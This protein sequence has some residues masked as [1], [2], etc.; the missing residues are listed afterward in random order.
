MLTK[1]AAVLSIGLLALAYQA[2]LP[3]PTKICGTPEG[4]PITAPRVELR[5]GRHLAYKEHG[6][7]K[8]QAKYKVIFVHGFH[9][10]RHHVVIKQ[11]L[12]K[13]VAEELGV[14]IVS[15]DRPGYGESDP[16]PKRTMKSIALDI[17]ELAD[18]LK[19]GEKF[20]VVGFSMGGQLVWA[21]LKYIP[22]RL[23]GA[24][25]LAPV[26]N[27]WWKGF[28][29]NLS[30]EAYY[31]Q[32]PQDQWAVRVAHYFPWLINW[33]NTQKWFPGSSAIAG[34]I[35]IF[36]PQDL[37]ILSRFPRS[38]AHQKQIKQQGQHESLHRDM[39]CGFGSWEFSP[40]ELQNPFPNGE[41]AV[42]LWQG[43]DDR[44]V[45][46]SLQRYIV[47]KLPWI[48]YHELQG[49]GHIFPFVESVAILKAQLL[50]ENK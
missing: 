37:Q 46:V 26:V 9:S 44:L 14:Y 45:P 8:E 33:W 35:K 36:S 3:E 38:E 12:A 16:D 11:N 7:P 34:N 10:C 18:K 24:T 17:E 20:Y 4:P 31:E 40:L 49:A 30:T 19:L 28:P 6:V 42:H 43:D 27:Y 29:S 50:G 15:F 25:L 1:V 39:L 47:K 41:G 13:D 23:A 48:Q 2:S 5:D 21:C 22:H 32:M